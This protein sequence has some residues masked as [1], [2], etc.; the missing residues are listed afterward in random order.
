MVEEFFQG[1]TAVFR[2]EGGVDEFAQILDAGVGLGRVF[3]FEQLDVLGAV[4]EELE[5]LR[6][7]RRS[8]GSAEGAVV[9]S[10]GILPAVER[11][12]RPLRIFFLLF[13]RNLRLRA[14]SKNETRILSTVP[15][16]ER[17]RIELG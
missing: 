2:I 13:A 17:E 4:N 3:V 15:E 9:C 16:I 10:A 8:A 7:I 12:S 5:H 6:C 1:L 11:A 14:F